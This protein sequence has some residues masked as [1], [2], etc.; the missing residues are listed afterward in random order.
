V[1]RTPLTDKMIAVLEF[2]PSCGMNFRAAG[3]RAGYSRAYSERIS[4]RVAKSE[5]LQQALLDRMARF[6][7]EAPASER[8]ALRRKLDRQLFRAHRKSGLCLP[9]TLVNP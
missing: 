5:V 3:L 4:Y 7:S 2:L 6:I 9:P 8:E 1:P